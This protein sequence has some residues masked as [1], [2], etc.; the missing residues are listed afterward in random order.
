ML[1]DVHIT[2]RNKFY[3]E[4]LNNVSSKKGYH[5]CIPN[6]DVLNPPGTSHVLP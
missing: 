3:L 1:Y 4:K 5:V 2:N 6:R